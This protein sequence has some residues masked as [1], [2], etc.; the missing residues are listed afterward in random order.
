MRIISFSKK[1]DKLNQPVFTTF[2]LPRKDAALGRDWHENEKVQV[3]YHNRCKDREFMGYAVI[4]ELEKT[5]VGIID[6]EQAIEDGFANWHEMY[7]WLC[8]AHGGVVTLNT[9]IN[10]LTI[11]W[12]KNSFS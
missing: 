10:K 4:K 12:D 11:T 2:G 6:D 7:D 5:I 9:I 8:K 3:Y 1:W